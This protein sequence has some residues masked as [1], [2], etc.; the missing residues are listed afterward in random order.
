MVTRKYFMNARVTAS[1][2]YSYESSIFSH[3]SIFADPVKV[4]E[5][6]T[7]KLKQAL[8]ERR[9]DSNFEVISFNQI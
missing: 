6:A 7:N 5:Y 3:K 9:P 2:G 4:Y 8:L 1:D